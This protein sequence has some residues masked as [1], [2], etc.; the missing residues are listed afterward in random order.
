[1]YEEVKAN[2]LAL[3]LNRTHQLLDNYIQRAEKE[4]RSL[5]E[6]LHDLLEAEKNHKDATSLEIRTKVAGFPSRK[7]FEQF[8][9]GF[10]PSIDLKTINDLRTMRF[11]HQSENVIFLGPPGVGKTHLAT[12]L[13]MDAIRNRF[14][15][16]Y[17]NCHELMLSLKKAQY[18]NTLKTK[19]KT[20]TKYKVLVIDEVGYLPLDIEAANLFFQLISQKYEKN[21]VI[22]TSNKGYADWGNIFGDKVIASAILDRL[23]HHGT[24]I[25]IK[26]DSYRLKNKKKIFLYD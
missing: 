8:D 4:S 15:V 6:A 25:N 12:A 3:K 5:L 16:Y 23:L 14:S 7:T 2:L 19:L 1:M 24:T 17:Q 13:G 21:S 22:L 26:G 11:V 18:E 9:F 10:Q 20:L